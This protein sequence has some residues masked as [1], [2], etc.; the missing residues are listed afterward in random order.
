MYT[1]QTQLPHNLR[2]IFEETI[3]PNLV[4][5]IRENFVASNTGNTI[6]EDLPKQ[7]NGTIIANILENHQEL[8]SSIQTLQDQINNSY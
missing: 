1:T 7:D 2:S 4:A 3:Q 5:V 6:H 8:L